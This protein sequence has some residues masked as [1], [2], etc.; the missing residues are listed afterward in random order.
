MDAGKLWN[1]VTGSWSLHL[2][3]YIFSECNSWKVCV[4]TRVYKFPVYA[5]NCIGWQFFF[6]RKQK[7]T[8]NSC[9]NNN[10]KNWLESEGF[11]VVLITPFLMAFFFLWILKLLLLLLFLLKHRWCTILYVTGVQY[12]DSHFLK[13]IVPL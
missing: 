1:L 12:S 13:V 5:Y 4:H 9:V 2:I 7:R 3:A 8:E 6:P 11:H 10:G